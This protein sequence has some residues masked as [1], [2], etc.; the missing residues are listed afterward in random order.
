[1][2]PADNMF[3]EFY[4]RQN[5]NA[6]HVNKQV[7]KMEKSR[8]D[9]VKKLRDGDLMTNLEKE[10]AKERSETEVSP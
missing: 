2:K 3:L 6:T 10:K 7:S 8:Y 9:F 1:M 5:K 4:L